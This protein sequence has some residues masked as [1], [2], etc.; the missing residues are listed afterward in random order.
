MAVSPD[1]SLVASLFDQRHVTSVVHFAAESHVDRSTRS[2]L[3]FVKTNIKGTVVLLEE[4]REERLIAGFSDS[5][6]CGHEW[7]APWA[8]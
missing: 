3:E 1:V 5:R 2:P 8:G 7:L 4:A 6:V